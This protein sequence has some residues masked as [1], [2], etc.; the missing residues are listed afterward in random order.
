[1]ERNCTTCKHNNE[2]EDDKCYWCWRRD[3]VFHTMFSKWE[4]KEDVPDINVG[5]IAREDTDDKD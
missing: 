1:M 2:V 5:E 3:T 4:P